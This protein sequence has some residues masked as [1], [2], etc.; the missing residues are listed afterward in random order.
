MSPS[1]EPSEV[2]SLLVRGAENIGV[3]TSCG[4]RI[5]WRLN[6]R[7]ALDELC[8][9]VDPE[10][11]EVSTEAVP[12]DSCLVLCP[13]GDLDALLVNITVKNRCGQPMAGIPAD[14][15]KVSLLRNAIHNFRLCCGDSQSELTASDPTDANGFTRVV[16]A[17]GAGLDPDVGIRV[18]VYGVELTDQPRADL[19]SVAY[20]GFCTVP[21]PNPKD[22]PDLDCDGVP[23]DSDDVAL[24]ELHAGHTCPTRGAGGDSPGDGKSAESSALS[25]RLFQNA[26]NPF[27]GATSVIWTLPERLW[28]KV[29]IYDAAGRLVSSLADGELDAGRYVERWDG[30]DDSGR[31]VASGTYF[32]Q[33]ESS[34]GILRIKATLLR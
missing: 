19:R 15:I 5:M 34:A 14:D 25:Y 18:S 29:G 26:P 30:M 21:V 20:T 16:I 6:V 8:S 7:G 4:N 12:D 3:A 17:H 33:V 22:V 2:C 27:S 13:A 11:S 10:R 9:W 31:Q 23:G 32:C 1:L 28:V 24:V